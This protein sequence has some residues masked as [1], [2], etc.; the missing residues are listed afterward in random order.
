MPRFLMGSEADQQRKRFRIHLIPIVIAS[1]P[2][3]GK[4]VFFAGSKLTSPS[5]PFPL[6]AI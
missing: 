3:I 1:R 2:L 4:P 6:T 5:G